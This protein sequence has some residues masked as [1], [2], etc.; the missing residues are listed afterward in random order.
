[1]GKSL[2]ASVGG[3][4]R[5]PAC[6]RCLLAC[7]FFNDR[8]KISG[9]SSLCRECFLAAQRHRKFAARANAFLSRDA[10]EDAQAEQARQRS[11][12]ARKSSTGSTVVDGVSHAP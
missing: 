1:V 6:R 2:I 8:S 7:D 3:G 11:L 4:R 5:C 10:E 12:T 9:A